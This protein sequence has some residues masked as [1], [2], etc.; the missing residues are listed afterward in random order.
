MDQLTWFKAWTFCTPF[1]SIELSSPSGVYTSWHLQAEAWV[2][3]ELVNMW[4]EGDPLEQGIYLYIHTGTTWNY[5]TN[6]SWSQANTVEC[7]VTTSEGHLTCA[8]ASAMRCWTAVWTSGE[9]RRRG[10][11]WWLGRALE[12]TESLTHPCGVLV[13]LGK[14]SALCI[15]KPQGHAAE[16]QPGC[17]SKLPVKRRLVH[18]S[19]CWEP[20]QGHKKLVHAA[21]GKTRFKFGD[22]PKLLGAGNSL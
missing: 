4:N 10:T 2:F 17:D 7:T 1:Y 3:R 18:H 11:P 9:Q 13:F 15:W 19:T 21:A 8:T 12:H 5:D 20:G 14:N 16:A 22:P 6:T